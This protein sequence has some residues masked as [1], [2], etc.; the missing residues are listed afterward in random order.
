MFLLSFDVLQH[1]KADQAR[2]PLN[3]VQVPYAS[4]WTTK[5]ASS[6]SCEP[7]GD[8]VVVSSVF[9]SDWTFT[10]DYLCTLSTAKAV[11]VYSS[12]EADETRDCN[13][14]VSTSVVVRSFDLLQVDCDASEPKLSVSLGGC[15][16]SISPSL[17]YSSSHTEVASEQPRWSVVRRQT[18]GVDY[19]MLRRQDEPILFF[20]EFILYQVQW[21]TLLV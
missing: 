16:S 3:I 4:K 11:D 15:L 18:S 19:D 7:V 8:A 10:S 6:D 17:R 21:L 1:T 5:L 2:R 14:V 9:R 12:E 13:P 20:D